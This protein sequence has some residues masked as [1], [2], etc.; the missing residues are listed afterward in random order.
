MQNALYLDLSSAVVVVSM[1]I[2][3]SQHLGIRVT[4]KYNESVDNYAYNH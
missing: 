2:A 4:P 1:K 3:K